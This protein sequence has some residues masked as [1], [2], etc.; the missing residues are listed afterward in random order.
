MS[1]SFY[2]V[3]VP[4]IFKN[5]QALLLRV[6]LA[7]K[8]F[9]SNVFSFLGIGSDGHLEKIV[10]NC[11]RRSS[12]YWMVGSQTFPINFRNLRVF[13]NWKSPIFINF[14]QTGRFRSQRVWQWWWKGGGGG[15]SWKGTGTANIFSVTN[16]WQFAKGANLIQYFFL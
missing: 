15:W 4:F 10:A 5:H 1:T 2:L 16:W 12:Y 6:L 9:Y 11:R 14:I 8:W 3:K 7:T 13:I